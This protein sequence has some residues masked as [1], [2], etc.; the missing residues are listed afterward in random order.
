MKPERQFQKYYSKSGTSQTPVRPKAKSTDYSLFSIPAGLL[1]GLLLLLASE[2]PQLPR[3]IRIPLVQAGSLWLL[4]LAALSSPPLQELKRIFREGVAPLQIIFL[5]WC[6]FTGAIA[7]YRGF[8]VFEILRVFDGAAVFFITAY[9]MRRPKETLYTILG[10]LGMGVA[11]C[12]YDFLTISEGQGLIGIRSNVFG[13]H[14]NFGSLV[15]L[16]FPLTLLFAISSDT[17]DRIR[18]AGLISTPIIAGGLLLSLTRSAW[19]GGAA[20]LVALALLLLRVRSTNQKASKTSKMQKRSLSAFLG[21]PGFLISLALIG[22]V[23]AGGIGTILSQRAMTITEAHSD[24]SFTD[25]L[26]KWRGAAQMTAEKP[27]TGWGLGSYMVIQQRW[28]HQGDS[29]A[30]TLSQGTDHQNIAHNYYVQWAADSGGI[31]VALYVALI[32][33]FLILAI[34]GL[35]HFKTPS[36]ERAL[37]IGCVATVFGAAVDA[38]GAPSYNFHGVSS[39]FWLFLGTGV[40]VM[41][42]KQVF[43]SPDV[44]SGSGEPS[45]STGIAY[46]AGA[47]I[48]LTVAIIIIVAGRM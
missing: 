6:L 5:A 40:A 15:M 8:A 37:L 32:V 34:Q 30:K 39:V 43:S 24:S 33:T 48:G 29:E 23:I 9:G 26:L 28:T 14:E 7:P 31:G 46:L 45:P 12:L 42:E 16:M 38:I 2:S 18:T 17:D 47:G 41:R 1:L 19:I 25:R 22:L 4:T 3:S 20:A 10:L 35:A 11:L 36:I 13:T 27:L 21:S 44:L